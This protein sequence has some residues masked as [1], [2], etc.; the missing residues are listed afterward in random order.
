MD[1]KPFSRS[2]LIKQLEFE[3]FTHEQ[4]VAGADSVGL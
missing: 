2:G 3:G 1:L 4:A